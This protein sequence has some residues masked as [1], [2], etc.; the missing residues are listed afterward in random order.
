MGETAAMAARRR[1]WISLWVT[2]VALVVA[3]CG[4]GTAGGRG[5]S[6]ADGE[7]GGFVAQV[8]SFELV[9]GRDQRFLAA[10]AGEGT[11]TVVSFGQVDLQFSYLGTRE[12]PVDPPEARNSTEASFLPIPGAQ[13]DPAAA[14]P[15]EVN[16]SE[17]L[18]VY[19]AE[20]VRFDAAGFW[21]VEVQ[22]R[23]EGRTVRAK[24][25][26]EVYAEPQLPFP[27]QPAPRTDN[28][29]A[30]AAGVEPA[31][32]DSRARGGQPVPD[33]D[34]H[35]TSVAEALAAGR[36][37]VV[38]VSTPVYCVSRFCGPVTD[39]VERL[40]GRYGDRAAFVHLEVWQDFEAKV[41]NPAAAEWIQP[42]DRGDTQEPWVFLVGGDGIV[43][44]R[45]DNVVSDAAL[46]AAVKELVGQA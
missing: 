3:S 4:G 41:V 12:Q 15:R 43:R 14:G 20:P 31:A 28:P 6:A 18:G 34:L 19:A 25:A 8:A 29:V 24:A 10:L 45:F 46:E 5:D 44:K 9:A 13:I 16:P 1:R 7:A 38:V 39:S 32:I 11:G 21:G 35:T 2:L 26:F 27:G 36:P 37:T 17:G 40:A 23:I 22:A 33:P 30:G 42:K